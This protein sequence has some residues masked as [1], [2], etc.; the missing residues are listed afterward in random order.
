MRIEK[1]VAH[2][3]EVFADLEMDNLRKE[4]CLCLNCS[5][6]ENSCNTSKILYYLSLQNHVAM[7]ITRCPQYGYK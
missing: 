3:V 2:D 1:T 7:M 6:T 4:R 5:K